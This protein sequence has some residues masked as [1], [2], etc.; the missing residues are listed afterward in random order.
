[1]LVLIN[2]MKNLKEINKI[3]GTKTKKKIDLNSYLENY[4]W[5]SLAMINL[6]TWANNKLK[7]KVSGEDL[8]KLLKIKDLDNL[9]SKIK[10]KK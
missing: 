1:M 8:S 5:D 3:L 4:N 10:K 6:I 7:T 2:S 9:L